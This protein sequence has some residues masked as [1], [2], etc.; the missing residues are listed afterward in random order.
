MDEGGLER[1][2]ARLVAEGIRDLRH[3]RDEAALPDLCRHQVQRPAPYD[4]AGMGT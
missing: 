3:L 4:F 1:A 2:Y